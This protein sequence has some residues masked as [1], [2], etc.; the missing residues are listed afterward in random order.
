MCCWF[1]ATTLNTTCA[2]LRAVPGRPSRQNRLS[3]YTYSLPA[4]ACSV[5]LHSAWTPPSASLGAPGWAWAGRSGA[6]AAVGPERPAQHFCTQHSLGT[7][8][9]LQGRAE[10]GAGLA[11]LGAGA[12]PGAGELQDICGAP[13]WRVQWA[14]L[15]GTINT[16]HVHVPHYGAPFQPAGTA[17]SSP[18]ARCR[19]SPVL[20]VTA[21]Q[22]WCNIF[23]SSMVELH[24]SFQ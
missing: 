21:K 3:L 18:A 20:S 9:P 24:G 22:R 1:T 7:L 16:L 11:A 6:R 23:A 13:L 5:S 8:K 10:L 14:V 2:V 4:S 19:Y 12:P 17:S 15:P